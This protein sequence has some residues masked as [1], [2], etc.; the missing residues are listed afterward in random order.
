MPNKMSMEDIYCHV[1]SIAAA[2]KGVTNARTTEF[3]TSQHKPFACL[4]SFLTPEPFIEYGTIPR[5]YEEV[6]EPGHGLSVYYGREG[7]IDHPVPLNNM[8]SECD[9][10]LQGSGLLH[11]EINV[12]NRMC[13]NV[14]AKTS[15]RERIVAEEV[16][17]RFQ[18]QSFRSG[19]KRSTEAFTRECRAIM[20]A[21]VRGENAGFG[22]FFPTVSDPI[23]THV[24]N[25]T[26]RTFK[27]TLPWH[28]YRP[29]SSMTFPNIDLSN[30][31]QSKLSSRHKL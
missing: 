21:M 3:P 11:S 28:V 12:W 9:T 20:S 16:T 24:Y 29:V 31:T 15:F 26:P 8:S 5:T 13:A 27:L 23:T 17:R 14:S 22:Q 1:R 6:G 19:G 30:F 10:Y 7:E 2:R 18:Q 25:G 4:D